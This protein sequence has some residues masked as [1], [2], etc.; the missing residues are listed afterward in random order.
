[1]SD[2]VKKYKARDVQGKVV[3]FT[4]DDILGHECKHVTYCPPVGDRDTDY[5]V[6]KR[7]THLKNGTMIPN[8]AIEEDF[9]FNIWVT[10]KGR[11]T[12]KEKREFGE[13]ED[14]DII[15]TTRSKLVR[16]IQAKLEIKSGGRNN[17]LRELA[18][19]PYLYGTDVPSTTLLKRAMM[20]RSPDL[21]SPYTVAPTDT[22]TNMF[23]PEQEIIMQ[24]ITM[25]ERVFV[26]I[27][28]SFFGGERSDEA[29]KQKLRSMFTYYLGDLEKSRNITLEIALVDTSGQVVVEVMKRAH[30][31]K[32]D[33]LAIWNIKFDM[34]K[35]LEALKADHIDPADVFSDPKVVKEGCQTFEF[36]IGRD[37][38]EKDDGSSKPL[39]NHEQWH[40]AICPASFYFVDAM[41]VY[42][43]VRQGQ[44]EEHSYALD[45]LLNK[46]IKRGKLK[47]TE[48]D[49]FK[50]G[51]WHKFMQSNYKYEY[52]IYN[53]F[54]CI[55][56][57]MLDEETFDLSLSFPLFSNASDF[58]V[59]PSQPKK[60]NNKLYFEL[61]K[62]SRVSGST[63]SE[64][65]NED[66]TKTVNGQ[67]WIT[68][69]YPHQTMDNGLPLLT[70][71]A[72]E[73]TT[74]YIGCGDLD[75][76]GTYPTEGIVMN[77]SKYTT[78]RELLFIEGIPDHIRRRIGFNIAGGHV[79]AVEICCDLYKA[80]TMDQMLKAFEERQQNK[81]RLVA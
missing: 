29:I 55:G 63:S 78:S 17:N 14:L 7:V 16:N 60:L 27:K 73:P 26:A 21:R 76:T 42:R 45:A 48:A 44:Q 13:M 75:I 47:F 54:D 28:R 19:S 11:R 37:T 67:G 70:A 69:L 40:Y 64:M 31:W 50:E 49:G 56:M 71:A 57:E 65:A 79:N 9:K 81:D 24:S 72:D 46:H 20:D 38:K 22:E 3:E 8:V 30:A 39:M 59:F 6:I 12:Y 5:H 66:D 2:Q 25:K 80:P 62:D 1:M 34:K 35:M 18:K 52:V 4:K 36:V 10:K 32:P 53:I 33:F 77:I 68:M 51:E 41:C 15:E 58:A 23:S 61:L 43:Q 74:I